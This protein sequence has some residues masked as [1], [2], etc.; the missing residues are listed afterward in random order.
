M[1]FIDFLKSSCS[2]FTV[3]FVDCAIGMVGEGFSFVGF[4]DCLAIGC[5][6]DIYCQS[7]NH[8]EDHT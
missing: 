4:S 6:W 2:F 1:S 7:L 5:R 3:L 8:V